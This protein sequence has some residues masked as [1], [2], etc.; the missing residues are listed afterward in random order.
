L[1]RAV[2]PSGEL[3]SAAVGVLDF[4]GADAVR[5]FGAAAGVAAAGAAT[6]A[7]AFAFGAAAGSSAAIHFDTPPWPRHAPLLWAEVVYVPSL[8]WPVA[9]AGA[10]AVAGAA[11]VFDVDDAFGAVS[12]DP[13]H[14][15]TPP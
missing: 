8:H 14:C 3:G 7:A 13:I 9:P 4:A 2:A 15:D 5:A 12:V 11:L 6:G 10:A 1:Q